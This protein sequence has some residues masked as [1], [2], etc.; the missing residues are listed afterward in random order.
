MKDDRVDDVLFGGGGIKTKS[1][2][3]CNNSGMDPSNI[4]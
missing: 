3:D 2:E 4:Y 1:D